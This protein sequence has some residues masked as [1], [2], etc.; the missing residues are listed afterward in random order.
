MLAGIKSL[1]QNPKVRTWLF[2]A[3]TLLFYYT[4]TRPPDPIYDIQIVGNQGF[5]AVGKTGVVVV[6]LKDPGNLIEVTSL[7][8]FGAAYSLQ[9]LG[10][11]VFVADGPDGLKMLSTNKEGLELEGS[12]RTPGD[13]LDI[14]VSGS[15]KE[16]ALFY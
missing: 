4:R 15:T 3:F 11:S 16:K 7:D 9:V 5:L 6:D 10:T 8:T 13:A 2:I 1:L 12:Y 14:A